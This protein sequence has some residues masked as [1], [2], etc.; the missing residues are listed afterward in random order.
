[1]PYLSATEK[2]A[3]LARCA[4]LCCAVLCCAVL[5]CAVNKHIPT[6]HGVST[7]F[8]N[9]RHIFIHNYIYHIFAYFSRK[10]CFLL[11]SDNTNVPMQKKIIDE[12]GSRNRNPNFLEYLT[13]VSFEYRLHENNDFLI[14]CHFSNLVFGISRHKNNLCLRAE[15]PDLL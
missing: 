12:M 5:C 2:R 6:L 14:T 10:F 1:M 13:Q 8:F 11:F 7:P 4:V 3:Q 15:P 9:N